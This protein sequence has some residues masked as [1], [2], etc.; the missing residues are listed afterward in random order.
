ML[1]VLILSLLKLGHKDL[2]VVL[3]VA[4]R[5]GYPEGKVYT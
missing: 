4:P 2:L 1:E 3:E 5:M